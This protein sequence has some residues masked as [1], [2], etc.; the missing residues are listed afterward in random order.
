VDDLVFAPELDYFASTL[1][2]LEPSIRISN[3]I[4]QMSAT[5]GGA[6][7]CI[8]PCFMGDADKRLRRVLP[9]AIRLFRSYW[10]LHHSDL[11]NSPR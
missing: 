11:H 1:P 9:G 4:T 7:L 8:L 2:G 10:L 3:V 6:G 5:L